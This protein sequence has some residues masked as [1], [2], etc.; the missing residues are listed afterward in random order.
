MT[1]TRPYKIYRVE[2]RRRSDD[3]L[4]SYFRVVAQTIE[5]ARHYVLEKQ[6][7]LEL[8]FKIGK[9]EELYECKTF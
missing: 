3:T 9:A 8:Y 1:I 7:G 4:H 6:F 5:E 2:V